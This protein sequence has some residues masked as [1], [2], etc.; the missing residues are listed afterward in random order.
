[1]NRNLVLFFFPFFFFFSVR[2]W[3]IENLQKHLI[4]ALLVFIS[5]FGYI[6]IYIYIYTIRHKKKAGL[7]IMNGWVEFMERH[8]ESEAPKTQRKKKQR[9]VSHGGLAIYIL[10]SIL[11]QQVEL[12]N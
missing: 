9:G 7:R 1:M 5:P 12:I 2:F 11:R 6:Y 8:L 10:K 4:L 3:L